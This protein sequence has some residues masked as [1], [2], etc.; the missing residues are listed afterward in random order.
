[1]GDHPLAMLRE[2]RAVL[3]EAERLKRRRN[4]YIRAAAEAGYSERRIALAAGISRGQ[5]HRIVR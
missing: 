1:M 2:I 4:D 5:V 3:R